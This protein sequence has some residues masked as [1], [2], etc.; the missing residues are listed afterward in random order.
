MYVDMRAF[1]PELPEEPFVSGCEQ[2]LDL[3]MKIPA[4]VKLSCGFVN[5][6]RPLPKGKPPTHK[7]TVIYPDGLV[8]QGGQKK[9][10][11]PGD[12][13]EIP[14]ETMIR[15][16]SPDQLEDWRKQYFDA[17][18]QDEPLDV[19]RDQLLELVQEA[20]NNE[21][22]EE[23]EEEDDEKEEENDDDAEEDEEED[24]DPP[25]KL[26][27]KA[28]HRSEVSCHGYSTGGGCS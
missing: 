17:G 12:A 9:E 7:T 16:A 22:D 6:C 27:K 10:T 2:P 20:K 26:K 23:E 18:S 3:K 25:L 1:F 8:T 13:S 5:C 4:T 14:D 24:D 15:L 11:I 28:P 21:D 19:I